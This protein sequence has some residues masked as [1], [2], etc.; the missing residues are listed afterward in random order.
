M[1]TMKDIA[2]RAGVSTATVSRVLNHDETLS[3]GKETK[4]RIFAAAKEL[5]YTKTKK[6]KSREKILLLQWYT[7]EEELDDLY[8]Q[9]IRLGAE[10]RAEAEGY[11]VV[12]V[13]H[14]VT[15]DIEKGVIGIVAIGKFGERQVQRLMDFGKPLCFIDSDQFK[16]K[17]DCVIVDFAS[18]MEQVIAEMDRG[19]HTQIGFLEGK[20]LTNDKEML[21]RDLRS[22]LFLAELRKRGWYRDKYHRSG[23]FSTSSGYEMMN[24]LLN[25]NGK[26]LPTFLFAENDAIAIGA[27]RALQ[28]ADIAVPD[29]ISIVGF[30]D[31]KVAKYV[32]PSL[33]SIRVD[34]REM[35]RTGV[36][37]LLDR[38]AYPRKISKKISLSTEWIKRASTK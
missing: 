11:D 15:F 19:G 3:V 32:Y 16:W 37:L 4:D 29:Q 12:R 14:D 27:L 8:Y 36:S 33:S 28:E 13:F 24:Q 31:S 7:Q 1:A 26:Q 18:A 35:G 22:E 21:V 2:E 34:T 23:S 25:D 6:K 5:N 17:Q 30:N 38:I 20:E 10:E 9:G